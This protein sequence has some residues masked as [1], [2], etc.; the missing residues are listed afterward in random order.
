M[1]AKSHDTSMEI[2]T[3][4][5]RLL[6][7]VESAVLDRLY[8]KHKERKEALAAAFNPG[9][10][11]DVTNDQGLKLGTISMSQPNKK[12][13]PVDIS[14]IAV[15]ALERGYELTD[16]L[17]EPGSPNYD[18]AIQVLSE[19]APE[20][21]PPPVVP[22]SAINAIAQEM[23]EQWQIT[24]QPPIGWEIRDASR[25]T[26]RVAK[27]RGRE[28]KIAQKAIDH[29]VNQI[30]GILAIEGPKADKEGK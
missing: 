29:L 2:N 24:G 16:R 13:V 1:T 25:P 17:P 18:K 22:T 4:T 9:E 11:F 5:E 20:L 6:V 23:L 10:K 27:T 21:L 3:Q 14:V 12:A 30:D 26:F 8:A 15:Q 28:G 7:L 19:H